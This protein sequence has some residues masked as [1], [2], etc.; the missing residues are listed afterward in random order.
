MFDADRIVAW[1]LD[2]LGAW[3]PG[4]SLVFDDTNLMPSARTFTQAEV[5]KQLKDR[6]GPLHEALAHI[7]FLRT[8]KDVYFTDK[9]DSDPLVQRIRMFAG[10]YDSK[11]VERVEGDRVIAELGESD[12]QPTYRLTFIEMNERLTLTKIEYTQLEE[13][14]RDPDAIGTDSAT[15]KEEAR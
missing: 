3:L 14:C 10:K 4:D 9:P 7:A 13:D 11:L 15:T 1:P 6:K 8:A 12:R 5:L 2:A